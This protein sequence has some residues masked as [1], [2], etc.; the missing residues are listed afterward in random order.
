[1]VVA[2][3]AGAEATATMAGKAGRS[4]YVDA[5]VTDG[6][7]DPGAVAVAVAFKAAAAC[8]D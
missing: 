3:E 4:S 6:T 7:P 5:S 2:A 1:V 8:F